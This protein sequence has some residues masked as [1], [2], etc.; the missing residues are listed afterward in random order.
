MNNDEIEKFLGKHLLKKGEQ[1][2][3]DFKKRNPIYGLFLEGNDYSDLK[4]K[5]FWR[6]VTLANV[7][8]FQ[9]SKDIGLAKIFNGSEFS[10]LSVK[11]I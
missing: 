4:S 8:A 10:R 3:I 6:I 11:N 7:P 2:K 1:I 5:N 9:Q